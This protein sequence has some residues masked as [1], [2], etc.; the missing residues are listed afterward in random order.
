MYENIKPNEGFYNALFTGAFVVSGLDAW[1]ERSAADG[2][3]DIFVK[4]PTDTVRIFELKYAKTPDETDACVKSPRTAWRQELPERL[5]RQGAYGARADR[6][7][8]GT[9]KRVRQNQRHIRQTDGPRLAARP[10]A[11]D[12]PD[13]AALAR[14]NPHPCF[15]APPVAASRVI[16]S[17]PDGRRRGL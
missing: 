5:H 7:R 4:L 15:P 3:L 8:G 1:P 6:G 9:A 13:S 10:V 17:G 12:A 14:E 11:V 2:K 16:A